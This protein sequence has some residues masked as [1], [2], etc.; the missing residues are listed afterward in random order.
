MWRTKHLCGFALA[1]AGARPFGFKG[2]SVAFALAVA[3]GCHP[4]PVRAKRGRVRD[5]LLL[6]SFSVV[7]PSS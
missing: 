5:L 4:E 7:C 3:F 1:F 2:R 6:F